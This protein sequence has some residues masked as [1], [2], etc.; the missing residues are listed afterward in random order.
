MSA[1]PRDGSIGD[2]RQLRCDR[3]RRSWHRWRTLWTA[4]ALISLVPVLV[5][6][7][8]AILRQ[9][10]A[11]GSSL[12][13]PTMQ[14]WLALAPTFSP[15]RWESWA[16]FVGSL[17]GSAYL[18][19]VAYRRSRYSPLVLTAPHPLVWRPESN[20][21][22]RIRRPRLQADILEDCSRFPLVFLT[23]PSGAGKS[24]LARALAHDLWEGGIQSGVLWIPIYISAADAQ[25]DWDE[26]LE[27]TLREAC[28]R[29][30]SA[31]ANQEKQLPTAPNQPGWQRE[32]ECLV[33][34]CCNQYE[35]QEIPVHVL[36]IIDQVDDY[37]NR[38]ERLFWPMDTTESGNVLLRTEQLLE[39][40][41]YWR[42]LSSLLCDGS[43]R[44][45]YHALL[46]YR[47]DINV[48]VSCFE[49]PKLPQAP[50]HRASSV[51]ASEVQA[52]LFSSLLPFVR[53]HENRVVSSADLNKD[54]FF[55]R[56]FEDLR[57]K[58]NILP[59]Q[60]QYYFNGLFHLA[61]ST[62]LTARAYR[63][64]GGL[65]GLEGLAIRKSLQRCRSVL[66]THGAA[67]PTEI[68]ALALLDLL[69][70]EE[71]RP[72][73]PRPSELFSE[74]HQRWGIDLAR[75][76]YD[77]RLIAF[78][79]A[80]RQSDVP[81]L[82]ASLV[83]PGE[84][85]GAP[86]VLLHHDYLIY[87]IR[88]TLHNKYE[89]VLDLAH[90]LLSQRRVDWRKVIQNPLR[91]TR[92]LV[93]WNFDLPSSDLRRLCSA[94]FMKTVVGIIATIGMFIASLIL[95][96]LH[97]SEQQRLDDYV[98]MSGPGLGRLIAE[99]EHLRHGY[100]RH[101][102]NDTGSV[103][104]WRQGLVAATGFDPER[105]RKLYESVLA[106]DRCDDIVYPP[107]SSKFPTPHNR[108][109]DNRHLACFEMAYLL[110]LP[111]DKLRGLANIWNIGYATKIPWFGLRNEYQCFWSTRGSDHSALEM[112]M[113][114]SLARSLTKWS[115]S[116]PS[117]SQD[118][119][120]RYSLLGPHDVGFASLSKCQPETRNAVYQI[121]ANQ[122][123][124]HALK[125]DDL[126]NEGI[127]S[128]LSDLSVPLESN[129]VNTE[130]RQQS[131]ER[132]EQARRRLLTNVFSKATDQQILRFLERARLPLRRVGELFSRI[133]P[134][135]PAGFHLPSRVAATD[136]LPLMLK[137]VSPDLAAELVLHFYRQGV[138]SSE[139]ISVQPEYFA[140][141]MPF[142]PSGHRVNLAHKLIEQLALVEKADASFH[143]W[144]TGATVL[145]TNIPA[146]HAWE[147]AESILNQVI[148]DLGLEPAK[149]LPRPALYALCSLVGS[150]L[151]ALPAE[152]RP[153]FLRLFWNG[154]KR[155]SEFMVSDADR[156]SDYQLADSYRNILTQGAS[157]SIS[158]DSR[159]TNTPI[160]KSDGKSISEK[161]RTIAAAWPWSDA[162][163][164]KEIE[165]WMS[166]LSSRVDR[167][168]IDAG[169]NLA[170]YQIASD[171]LIFL[172]PARRLPFFRSRIFGRA[173]RTPGLPSAWGQLG[174]RS[175]VADLCT[176]AAG[177]Q[178][179][180]Q[181]LVTDYAGDPWK[182]LRAL[183]FFLQVVPVTLLCPGAKSMA[184]DFFRAYLDYVARSDISLWRSLYLGDEFFTQLADVLSNSDI[185]GRMWLEELWRTQT[186]HVHLHNI[187]NFR[188]NFGYDSDYRRNLLHHSF[189][190]TLLWKELAHK[191]SVKDLAQFVDGK[192]PT[193][194]ELGAMSA[195]Q[196]SELQAVVARILPTLPDSDLA[197]ARNQFCADFV[198]DSRWPHELRRECVRHLSS[199]RRRAALL[200]IYCSL[201]GQ[202][203]SS[204]E[205][206]Q[207]RELPVFTQADTL[208]HVPLFP[209]EFPRRG[210]LWMQRWLDLVRSPAVGEFLR[211]AV[212]RRIAGIL[213]AHG[214]QLDEDAA[215][216]PWQLI[217]WARREGFDVDSA[218]E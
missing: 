78:L 191:S 59:V 214:S 11:L 51:S 116:A 210:S 167:S 30:R 138:D 96:Y 107:D 105:R 48:D 194:A 113:D 183:S 190:Y 79:E 179:L 15:L 202:R 181:M 101:L 215:R 2:Q 131:S 165:Q 136:A 206:Q 199:E 28:I 146:E 54:H 70:D 8:I 218:L 156:G 29:L 69:A 6:I 135:P 23:G 185:Q 46:I 91:Y 217:P 203:C 34:D 129:S 32:L 184:A 37:M 166:H 42:Q 55:S 71:N 189:N 64:V 114:H 7:G 126:T 173:V 20:H 152:R 212:L 168:R 75:K 196:R 150:T 192:L 83:H 19:W 3:S 186:R 120:L 164:E 60:I 12:V 177:Q 155:L 134:G 73:Q 52:A 44:I 88:N 84:F 5:I 170:N 163:N 174:W 201:V 157:Q 200:A 68:E 162:I 160:G 182:G 142:L 121:I 144:R 112:R 209:D 62:A 77:E 45:S 100:V 208:E 10:S 149:Q 175:V 213:K 61:Q 27:F 122:A 154:Y 123:G 72:R 198:E 76:T 141:L 99:P 33:A 195:E 106:V 197:V 43:Y 216:D 21:R 86:A 25:D 132:L 137:R 81:L 17:I 95:L 67:A 118:E 148:N 39:K 58:G 38:F 128:L 98:K 130:I 80:L 31:L 188:A 24:T 65:S 193:Q 151:S 102:R 119:Y 187:M 115:F 147:L 211:A 159:A 82:R 16:L 124:D 18:S 74:L 133:P 87:G 139:G 9:L 204:D 1:D 40:N 110:E 103:W 143:N 153:D 117:D 22:Q 127:W 63:R 169:S 90:S 49:F 207:R 171:V 92:V 89:P 111:F 14:R 125:G 35:A 50:R 53:T 47:S 97:R 180:T 158:D 172:P 41:T 108:L 36:F 140:A 4:L 66:Q 13:T 178:T 145:L 85:T 161:T 176:T 26:H 109:L 205:Q 94:V 57:E 56:F 93:P 104:N